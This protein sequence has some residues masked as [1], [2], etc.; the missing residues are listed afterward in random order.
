MGRY[1]WLVVV[2]V[3]LSTGPV[4]GAAW[5]RERLPVVPVDGP[6][7]KRLCEMVR[8]DSRVKFTGDEVERG[9]ARAEHRRRRTAALERY[10]QVT[11][12][13]AGFRFREY[14]VG[15]KRLTLET[16]RSFG[17]APGVELV[18]PT[19]DDEPDMV[20]RVAAGP[21]TQVVRL[22]GKG[23]LGLRVTLRLLPG[24]HGD[25]CSRVAARRATRVAVDPLA[26]ELVEM[27]KVEIVHYRGELPGYHEAVQA[28]VRF[29]KPSAGSVDAPA[30]LVQA[31]RG[32]ESGLL[33]CYRKGLEGNARLRG[34]LVV[35]F[36]VD[37]AGH[38]THAKAEI[39]SLGD[40]AVTACVLARVSAFR[41]AK[42]LRGGGRV[43]VPVYFQAADD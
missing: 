5:G 7:L 25:P 39:N 33:Q 30:S 24:P 16:R 15:E 17:V 32:L 34:A 35:G 29:G 26:F 42:A 2:A 14:D 8:P 19:G 18:V 20:A 37:A 10:Y 22:R 6:G 1:R 43:S 36:H 4:S 38:V 23:K 11:V 31:L 12:P 9:R 40:D 21:A 3:A 28:V 13:A 27:G 41:L